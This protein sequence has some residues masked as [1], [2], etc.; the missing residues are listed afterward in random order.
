MA[1]A[2]NKKRT[3]KSKSAQRSRRQLRIRKRISGTAVRPRLVVNR[4]AR[5]VFVQVVDDTKGLTVA[6]ASTLE[7]DLRAFD[8]DKTAKAK[9]VGELVAERAKAAGIEAVVFDRGGN[10]Y[11]GRIAAVADGAREGGLSL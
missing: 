1:I 3:N 6:S 11:H 8:G 7:A 5:H 2:I 4:S 10:K 9:R